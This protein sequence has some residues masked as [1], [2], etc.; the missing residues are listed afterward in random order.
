MNFYQK[1][2]NKINFRNNCFTGGCNRRGAHECPAEAGQLLS[3]DNAV[4][5]DCIELATMQDQVATSHK[6]LL[7][8]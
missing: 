3:S 8:S 5:G 7:K 1:Q 4:N 6:P 2:Y